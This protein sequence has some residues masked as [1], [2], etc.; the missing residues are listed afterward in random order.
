MDAT[1][2]DTFIEALIDDLTPV[3]AP[4][5]DVDR[6]LC[7]LLDSPRRVIDE[8][9][10]LAVLAAAVTARNLFDHVIAQAVAAAERA[11]IP[12]GKHLRSGA[13]LLTALGVA[14]GA[15]HRAARVG[16]AA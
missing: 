13:D 5:D 6:T 7:H 14:P 12:A 9:P 8:Q 16:R 1:H 15:A 4:D 11:G 3:P 2:L 10:L